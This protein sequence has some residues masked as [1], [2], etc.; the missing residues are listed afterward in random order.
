[1][2][3]LTQ[4]MPFVPDS[5]EDYSW[6]P[7]FQAA[8][9]PCYKLVHMWWHGSSKA[10]CAPLHAPEIWPDQGREP[11]IKACL[12]SCKDVQGAR[13]PTSALIETLD[14]LDMDFLEIGA[15]AAVGEGATITAH[16]IRDG[17]LIFNQ[18]STYTPICLLLTIVAAK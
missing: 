12:I 15:G 10:E 1:M 7:C 6:Q 3:V 17:S 13:V 9:M 4:T 14:I 16:T 5:G 8:G 2:K 18:A 11:L